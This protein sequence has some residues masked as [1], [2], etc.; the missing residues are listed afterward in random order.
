VEQQGDHRAEIVARS[1]QT[2]QPVGRPMKVLA[3]D[4]RYRRVFGPYGIA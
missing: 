3:N 4:N 2:D 1:G